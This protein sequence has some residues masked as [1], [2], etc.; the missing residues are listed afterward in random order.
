MSK[1]KVY[2]FNLAL[3]PEEEI[4]TIN[5][6]VHAQNQTTRSVFILLSYFIDRFGMKDVF[7]DDV[8][9]ALFQRSTTDVLFN[10]MIG[11]RECTDFS[12][13]K[14][15]TG[16]SVTFTSLPDYEASKINQWIDT[17]HN[18]VS[19][20]RMAIKYFVSHFGYIDI[21]SFLVQKY[22]YLG[23]HY[24]LLVSKQILRIDDVEALYTV[25][26]DIDPSSAAVTTASPKRSTPGEQITQ[27]A[28]DSNDH[29]STPLEVKTQEKPD[30]ASKNVESSDQATS[31]KAEKSKDPESDTPPIDHAAF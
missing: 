25:E 10:K 15:K 6:W 20:F 24:D 31:N 30:R 4:A 29:T 14:T 13:M 21:S 28:L 19:S 1:R 22:L 9:P 5:K 8:H 7:S 17:Q 26:G 16:I 18:T 27:E 2:A 12:D 3:A 23:L 11:H